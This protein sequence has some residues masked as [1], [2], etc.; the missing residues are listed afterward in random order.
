M[1]WITIPKTA[2]LW[3]TRR[4][5]SF[6]LVSGCISVTVYISAMVYLPLCLLCCISAAVSA[7]VYPL[8]FIPPAIRCCLSDTGIRCCVS[9]AVYLPLWICCCSSATV[10][11]QQCIYRCVSAP[12]YLPLWMCI[13]IRYCISGA[14]SAAVYLPL[15]ICHSVC[16]IVESDRVKRE[17]ELSIL[18]KL[19]S[20][21]LS[22]CW[23]YA[24]ICLRNWKFP[25]DGRV[26]PAVANSGWWVNI[27]EWLYTNDAVH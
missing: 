12:V 17:I 11:L 6:F 14:V 18:Q 22:N 1:L 25:G 16:C 21:K 24:F 27:C 4:V 8:L 9:A 2:S 23:I 10:Y 20:T 3:V 13:L 26:A 19:L 15:Y 5:R 7:T